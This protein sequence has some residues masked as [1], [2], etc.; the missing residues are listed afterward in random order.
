[1]REFTEY[2]KKSSYEIEK[3]LILMRQEITYLLHKKEMLEMILKNREVS[4]GEQ[5]LMSYVK[6]IHDE[7]EVKRFFDLVL[8]PLTGTE[9]YFVSLS[10]RNKYLSEEEREVFSLGRTEMF[11]KTVV[12]KKEWNRFIR[13]LRK[14]E[15]DERGY[16]TRSNLPIPSKTLV[17]YININPSDTIK[18]MF[19]FQKLLQEYAVEIASIAFKN[20]KIE[21]LENRINKIDNNLMTCYQKS[22]GT[23]HWMD[24]DFDIVKDERVIES[25]NEILDMK[26]ITRFFWI[27]TKSGYHLLVDT[28]QVQCNPDDLSSEI[29]HALWDEHDIDAEEIIYNKNA[30]I[31]IPGT[32]QGDYPVRLI[33]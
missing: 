12:R 17:C 19:A 32:F 18:T 25:T 30:M 1:M 29:E 31:P 3:E 2:Y 16:T 26:G 5:T 23:K 7:E 27:D 4:E 11:N 14:M 15:C 24:F 9:C 6:L 10:A 28:N 8:P 13:A 22:T 33:L 21:N 20:G